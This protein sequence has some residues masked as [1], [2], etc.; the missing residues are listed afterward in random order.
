MRLLLTGFLILSLHAAAQDCPRSDGTKTLYKPQQAKFISPPPGYSAVFINHVGRHGA[1][2]LTKDVNTYPAYRLLYK[3]DSL[4]ELTSEGQKLWK[5]VLSLREIEVKGLKSISERGKEEQRSIARRMVVNYP[6]VFSGS[7][8]SVRIK[9]TKEIRTSQSA[10]AFLQGLKREVKM[11][12]VARVIDDTALRFYDLSPAYLDF[13]ER[14]AWKN[15][16]SQL[17]TREGTESL[18]SGFAARIFKPSVAL[19]KPDMRNLCLDI[20][21][22]ASIILS[23]A[24]ETAS[25]K[26]DLNFNHLFTCGELMSLSLVNQAED[27]LLKGPGMDSMG[28]QVKIAVPLLV[29]FLLNTDSLIQHKAPRIELRFAHAETLSP[30]AALLQIKNA[31][32]PAASLSD[33]RTSWN[34]S[35]IIP[36]SA[37]IQW[38][39]Y[40]KKNSRDLL[41]KIL[42]NE[43]ESEIKGLKTDRFPYYH[44]TDLKEF[45]LRLLETVGVNPGDD[46]SRFLKEVK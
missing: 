23:I 36:L 9:A 29:Q 4:N 40:R 16:L 17:E 35:E 15:Q 27:Y 11:L 5:M 31:S 18:F 44:W 30:F 14:G 8:L 41:V 26:V 45:Y 39:I 37:N 20:Y 28:I 2:H 13:E 12:K 21:G 33:L 10:D 1:R 42:L 19:S 32:R 3:A 38:V 25:A 43:K 34:A 6:G 24:A 7:A 22:F 46:M